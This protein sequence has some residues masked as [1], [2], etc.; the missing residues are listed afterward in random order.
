MYFHLK[1]ISRIRPSLDKDACHLAVQSFVISHLDY[2]NIMLVGLPQN[3]QC[4]TAYFQNSQRRT[5]K[6]CTRIPSLALSQPE[7]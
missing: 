3:L 2:A 6:A 1:E 5:H 7:N 4:S